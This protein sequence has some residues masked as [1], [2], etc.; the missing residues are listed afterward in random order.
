MNIQAINNQTSFKAL[1]IPKNQVFTPE[2]QKIVEFLKIYAKQKFESKRDRNDFF[3]N[4]YLKGL[5]E[6]GIFIQKIFMFLLIQYQICKRTFLR[7][8]QFCIQIFYPVTMFDIGNFRK[9]APKFVG[10]IQCFIFIA[11]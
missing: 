8:S 6:S 5:D 2:Q 4:F 7:D 9:Y 3:N 1:I 11:L 10:F